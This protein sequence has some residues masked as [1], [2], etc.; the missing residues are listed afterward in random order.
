VTCHDPVAL[1]EHFSDEKRETKNFIAHHLGLAF[2]CIGAKSIQVSFSGSSRAAADRRREFRLQLKSV[3][4]PVS[5]W[6]IARRRRI[7]RLP[8]GGDDLAVTTWGRRFRD[9]HVVATIS[10]I[11][12][13]RPWYHELHV[14]AAPV[15]QAESAAYEK[16]EN[17]GLWPVDGFSVVSSSRP[18]FKC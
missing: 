16:C 10:E 18:K 8:R 9:H 17:W 7:W 15:H 14:A 12:T 4:S 5:V 3:E 11:T 6:E 13:W 1:T 2:P